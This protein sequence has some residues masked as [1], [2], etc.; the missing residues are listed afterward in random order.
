MSSACGRL[1]FA[2]LADDGSTSS[3]SDGTRA[4][5]VLASNVV[6]F[7]ERPGATHSHVTADCGISGTQPFMNFGAADTVAISTIEAGLLRFDVSALAPGTTIVA[8][9]VH[10]ASASNATD[11]MGLFD[12]LESW[13]EGAG[14]A[15][16]GI[17]NYTMRT[18]TDAWSDPGANPP[19]S[20]GALIVG[21]TPAPTGADSAI[22]V[23]PARVQ[24]WIDNPAA[25]NGMIVAPWLATG[26]WSFVTR[27]ATNAQLRPLLIVT[28]Q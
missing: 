21:F 2:P 16:N 20:R 13:T 4:S 15:S 5:D 12:A 8:A 11:M 22:A 17:A 27:E 23:D 19:S 14:N 3:N 10:L 18:S 28:L 9:E 7:G 26:N 25:N 24:G 6:S 1:G